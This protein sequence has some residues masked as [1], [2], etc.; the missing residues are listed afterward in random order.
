M[1]HYH[2]NAGLEIKVLLELATGRHLIGQFQDFNLT[3]LQQS[4]GRLLILSHAE[5]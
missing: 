2:M 3:S 4:S 1:T 5:A